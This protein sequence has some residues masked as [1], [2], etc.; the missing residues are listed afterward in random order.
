MKV[1]VTGASGFV[2]SALCAR[3]LVENWTVLGS[4]RQLPDK[5]SAGV[6]YRLVSDMSGDTNWSEILTGVNTV[7]HCAARVHIMRDTATDPLDVFREVNVKGTVRLAEQAVD[8]GVKRLVFI[9]SLK[10]NGET[11][12]DHPFRAD[13]IPEPTDPYSIS[14]W[15]AEQ[16]LINIAAKT[17]L[18]VVII[19]PPLVYGI[20]VRA[21]FL[22]LMQ[23]VKFG[24]PLPLDAIKNRRSLVALDNLVAL[25]V[26]CLDNNDAANQTFLVSDGEDLS[27]PELLRRTATAMKKS[28]RLFPVS[29]PLLLKVAGILGKTDFALR[30]CSSLQADISKTRDLLGWTPPFTVNES[31]QKTTDYFLSH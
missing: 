26:T 8:G 3:L 30:L 16:A 29:V 27:T 23:A 14:K 4:V 7:V 1:L 15:E 25:I 19:R 17:G 24:L 13:D 6:N 11:T 9:S 5:I 12:A 2:G 31:L 20:G 21:N 18:E 28:A 22:R 10:V